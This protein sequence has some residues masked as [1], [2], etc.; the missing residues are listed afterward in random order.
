MHYQRNKALRSDLNNLRVNSQLEA[1]FLVKFVI[2]QDTLWPIFFQ[3]FVH[4]MV[5]YFCLGYVKDYV[6]NIIVTFLRLVVF[7]VFTIGRTADSEFLLHL[8]ED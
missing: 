1:K 7:S 5:T 8:I 6:V 4:D 2:L 3:L